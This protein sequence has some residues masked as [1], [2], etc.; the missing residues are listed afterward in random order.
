MLQWVAGLLIPDV[1]KERNVFI[2]IGQGVT[3]E[4]SERG[5]AIRLL[6][7]LTQQTWFFSIMAVTIQ[8]LFDA[9][10]IHLPTKPKL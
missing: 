10:P 4:R 6:L 1:S 7:D 5:A 3:E 2:F 8:T 9:N